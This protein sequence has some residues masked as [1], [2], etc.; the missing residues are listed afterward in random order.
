M[1]KSKIVKT[2]PDTRQLVKAYRA[3]V[4]RVKRTEKILRRVKGLLE[5]EVLRRDE[6]LPVIR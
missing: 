3:L 5:K 6:E 4:R 1:S 2:M